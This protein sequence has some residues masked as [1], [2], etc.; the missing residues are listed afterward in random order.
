MSFFRRRIRRHLRHLRRHR[1]ALGA[2]AT[3][4]NFARTGPQSAGLVN[5]NVQV[6]INLGD[7]QALNRSHNNSFSNLL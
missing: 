2:K 3:V 7:A 6:P 1:R 4:N 5:V